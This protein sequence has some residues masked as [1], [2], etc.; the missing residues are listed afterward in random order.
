MGGG[1]LFRW[2]V[3]VLG[4]IVTIM[5]GPLLGYMC[6][7]SGLSLIEKLPESLC[8]LFLQLIHDIYQFT[9]E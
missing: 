7:E 2:G 4:P 5:G 3:P 6:S 9:A 1:G 8:L